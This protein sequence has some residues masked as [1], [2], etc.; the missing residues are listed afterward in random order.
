MLTE[1]CDRLDRIEALLQ[2]ILERLVPSDSA[3]KWRSEYNQV[4][5]GRPVVILPDNDEPGKKHAR[6]I[7]MSL[8]GVAASVTILDLPG[9]PPKGDATDWFEADGTASKLYELLEEAKR[10]GGSSSQQ[11][12]ELSAE[13]AKRLAP[14]TWKP[15][16]VTALPE[17]A[18]HYVD[19]ASRAIGCDESYVALPLL[20]GFA[21]AIGNSRSIRLKRGWTEPSV[22]WSAL[23]GESGTLKS[24]ALDQ[25]LKRIRKRQD[26]AI[27]RHSL[28]VE[29]YDRAKA[30]FDAKMAHWKRTGA[31]NGESA[32]P[33]PVPPVCERFWVSDTTVEALAERLARAPRGLLL[34]REELAGWLGSFGQYKGGKGRDSAH[35]LTM[36]GARSLLMDRKSGD[37]TTIYVPRAALSICG[38]IQP[39]IL[40]LALAQEH[41]QSGLAARLLLAMPPR[42][43]KRWSEAVVEETLETELADIFDRLYGLSMTVD[44]EAE[45]PAPVP[46]NLSARAK[47]A[48]VAFYNEHAT[49]QLELTGDLAAAWSKLEGYAARLALVVHLARWAAGAALIGEPPGDVNAESVEAGIELSRWFGN[50]AQRVYAVLNE[51]DEERDQRELVELMQRKGGCLTVRELMHARRRYRTSAEDAEAALEQLVKEGVAIRDNT[52]P[53][54]AGGRPVVR[55]RLS[56][57][58]AGN[59]NTT[60]ENAEEI[61]VPLP[62]PALPAEV[63]VGTNDPDWLQE[64]LPGCGDAWE[65]PEAGPY[66]AGN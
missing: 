45:E 43:A 56:P 6:D 53:S 36:H 17:L 60:P 16:P 1:Q 31:K 39:G 13:P 34:W 5:R 28:A 7:A 54:T 25:P 51:S 37:A 63:G 18:R 33:E 30:V 10:A 55:Y 49:E 32:P 52:T 2:Q 4:L 38:G 57:G 15:F 47:L 9:V 20:T 48:W 50:E 46:L 12:V 64:R 27:R 62:L 44:A 42:K 21:A 61:E 59:G 29:D 22:L 40:R 24:P 35:F 14:P 66:S 19:A 23:I 26:E 11:S 65:L 58:N 3:G 8:E 41:F